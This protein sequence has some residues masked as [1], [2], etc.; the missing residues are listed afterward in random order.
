[1]PSSS[2][3]RL[4]L[5]ALAAL[6]VGLCAGCSSTQNS[7]TMQSLTQRRDFKE[8][9]NEAYASLNDNGDYDIVLVHDVVGESAS[10]SADG[11]LQP[12]EVSPRQI[13]HIRVYWLARH[14]AKLDHPVAANATFRWFIF[15]DRIDESAELLEYSGGGLVLVAESGGF[16]YITIRG[17]DLSASLRRG[18]MDDPLGPCSVNGDITALVDRT[19]VDELLGEAKQADQPNAPHASAN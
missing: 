1:M 7:L 6:A 11:V 15:G 4:L 5:S 18:Q 12:R 2:P 3:S 17:A 14:G 16:S 8:Q 19:R 10:E 9:F 13:M